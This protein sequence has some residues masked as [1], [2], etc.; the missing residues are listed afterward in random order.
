MTVEELEGKLTNIYH[1]FAETI[2]ENETDEQIVARSKEW[3]VKRLSE[4][5]DNKEAI[6]SIANQLVGCLK[7]AS[8]LSNLEKEKM[9]KVWMCSGSTYTQVSSGYSVEQSLPVGIYSICLTMTGYHLDRYADKFVFPYKM[10][11]LQNEFIDHVIKTYHATEGNLGIM[12]TGTKGTGKTVTAKEL[13]NKLNLPIIIVK[14]MGDHNQSMIEFLSGIEGDCILFLDE[15][16]KN[17][18]ESDSTIL[19]IMDGVYNSKYRKVFLLTT[20]AMTINENMV[21]RPSRIRYVKEFGNLDALNEYYEYRRHNFHSL[22]YFYVSSDIKFANLSVGDDFY[23]EEIIAI[24]KK[25]GIV[26]TKENN[27]VNYYWVKDP[28]S[29]PSLYRRGTY[30]SLVL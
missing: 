24:D 27:E 3:F 17:F 15:F 7:Q 1:E 14:D 8:V 11:G 19:Q 25:L 12:L 26:V 5:T 16:E 29:K 30:N 20:N 22:S 9:N 10:Y 23:D 4:E 28:N 13:A 6:E 21:G 2:S 18:S